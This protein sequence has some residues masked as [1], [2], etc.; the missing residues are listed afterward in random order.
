[1]ELIGD[2]ISNCR[3]FYDDGYLRIEHFNY[4]ISC[5]GKQVSLNRIEFLVA[6]ILALHPNCFVAK[7]EIWNYIWSE[8]KPLNQ[9]SL[10]VTIHHLRRRLGAYDVV[11]QSKFGFGYRLVC[12]KNL[13]H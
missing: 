9:K 6:S 5:G 7:N 13:D 10:K 8:S 11:I 4:Y 12:E 2:A 3:D 1:M